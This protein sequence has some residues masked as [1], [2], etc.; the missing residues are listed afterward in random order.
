MHPQHRSIYEGLDFK[1]VPPV[2]TMQDKQAYY[3]IQELLAK[4]W[5]VG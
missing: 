2:G 1:V 4:M 5:A 3:W